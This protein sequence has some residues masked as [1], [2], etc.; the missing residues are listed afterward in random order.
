[1]DCGRLEQARIIEA[2]TALMIG[3]NRR[4]KTHAGIRVTGLGAALAASP[5]RAG[6]HACLRSRRGIA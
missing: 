4:Y 5:E 1:M 6:A 2:L 3:I